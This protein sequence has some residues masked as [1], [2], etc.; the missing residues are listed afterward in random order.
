MKTKITLGKSVKDKVYSL[1]SRS[2][3]CPVRSEMDISV[4]NLVEDSVYSP[5]RTLTNFIL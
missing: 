5:I 3:Y 2:V 4:S 1:V